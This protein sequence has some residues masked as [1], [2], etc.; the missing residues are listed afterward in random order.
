MD[1]AHQPPCGTDL[2][3]P[4]PVGRQRRSG[5]GNGGWHAKRH[6]FQSADLSDQHQHGELCHLQ[7]R[8]GPDKHPQ[9]YHCPFHTAAER[10]AHRQR[11][12]HQRQP[13]PVGL[14]R[15]RRSQPELCNLVFDQHRRNPAA[16]HGFLYQPGHLQHPARRG[17]GG[18]DHRDPGNLCGRV[19]GHEYLWRLNGQ[20]H[21]HRES[22][23]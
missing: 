5:L 18:A 6:H 17:S 11:S 13:V 15:A 7:Q 12:D 1:P 16:R 10:G 23:T 14:Y 22:G 4:T 9:L 20:Y 8:G 2:L 21:Y 19:C 3:D